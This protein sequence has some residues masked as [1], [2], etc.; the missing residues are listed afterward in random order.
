[1]SQ[2]HIHSYLIYQLCAK[3]E[4]KLS[5]LRMRMYRCTSVGGFYGN[6]SNYHELEISNC[7]F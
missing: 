5:V 3:E 4:E 7:Q 2:N 6:E 1:M